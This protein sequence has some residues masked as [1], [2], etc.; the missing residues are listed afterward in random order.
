MT[1]VRERVARAVQDSGVELKRYTYMW[2]HPQLMLSFSRGV[3]S[4]DVGPR[5][6]KWSRLGWRPP[7]ERWEIV[8]VQGETF[9]IG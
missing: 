8:V 5:V 2:I 1:A 4:A 6:A 7:T 3:H 9:V